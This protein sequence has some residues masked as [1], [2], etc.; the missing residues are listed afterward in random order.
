MGASDFSHPMSAVADVRDQVQ[1]VRRELHRKVD[2]HEV[3]SL[4]REV[5][6]LEH[7]VREARSSLDGLR[8]EYTR[9]QN[10]MMARIE[11]LEQSVRV[12]PEKEKKS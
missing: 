12:C 3:N 1:E 8:D 4:R 11:E 5:A 6:G 7:S 10:E 2:T 9:L